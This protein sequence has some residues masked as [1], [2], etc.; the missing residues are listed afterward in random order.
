MSRLKI[1][2]GDLFLALETSGDEIRHY[3]DLQTGDVIPVFENTYLPGDAEYVD[4][5]EMEDNPRY[6]YI[7]PVSSHDAYRWMSGF[8][9]AVLDPA[10]RARLT[11]ALERS[12]PFRSF[13]DALLSASDARQLWFEFHEARLREYAKDWLESAGISAELTDRPSADLGPDLQ[14]RNPKA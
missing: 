13:K 6:R 10:L 7:E 2:L 4:I 5:D 9:H 11:T 8:A 12:H 3:I 14:P 1:D